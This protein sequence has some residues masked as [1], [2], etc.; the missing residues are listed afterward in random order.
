MLH[1]GNFFVLNFVTDNKK[2]PHT[3]NSYYEHIINFI[4]PVL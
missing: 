1:T 2:K 4:E 3:K